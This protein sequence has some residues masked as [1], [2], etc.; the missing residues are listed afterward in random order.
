[1]TTPQDST[2]NTLALNDGQNIGADKIMLSTTSDKVVFKDNVDPKVVEQVEQ[3]TKWLVDTMNLPYYLKKDK[4]DDTARKH[5]KEKPYVEETKAGG[6]CVTIQCSTGCYYAVCVPLIWEWLKMIGEPATWLEGLEIL[7]HGE[8]IEADGLVP[9]ARDLG[10]ELGVVV[11]GLLEG[12]CAV[13]EKSLGG[14]LEHGKLFSL[15]SSFHHVFLGND[16]LLK[17]LLQGLF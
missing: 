3:D 4:I 14:R 17:A 8:E 2:D 12:L 15:H 7:D 5:A 16:H 6:S 1:M 11:D 9:S 10:A 13:L